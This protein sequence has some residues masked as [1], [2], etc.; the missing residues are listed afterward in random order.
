MDA[1]HRQAVALETRVI[2]ADIALFMVVTTALPPTGL[3]TLSQTIPSP[4]PG[5]TPTAFQA[6]KIAAWCFWPLNSLI[7]VCGLAALLVLVV[8]GVVRAN[9]VAL[10]LIEI[11][12]LSMWLLV[13]CL[14]L[15]SLSPDSLLSGLCVLQGV[16]ML[17]V[18]YL[19]LRLFKSKH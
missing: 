12:I 10:R 4:G 2:L 3:K 8:P 6:M 11:A 14:I 9:R 1:H 19:V 15:V 7:L 13:E 5:M 16:V 18:L 17:V